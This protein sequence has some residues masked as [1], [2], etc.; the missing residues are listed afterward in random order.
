MTYKTDLKYQIGDKIF[1]CVKSDPESYYVYYG[2]II[3]LFPCVL[4]EDNK[5]DNLYEVLY[6]SYKC[7]KNLADD[8]FENKFGNP[9]VEK[10]TF[11]A[12]ARESE[13]FKTQEQAIK[14]CY[15]EIERM[16]DE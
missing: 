5:D 13:L 9:E 8:V 12:F 10:T 16:Q 14:F 11:V 6:S 15:E 7:K 4:Y 3:N 1:Y 2:E